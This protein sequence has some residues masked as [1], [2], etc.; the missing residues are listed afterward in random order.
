MLLAGS[1]RKADQRVSVAT[2]DEH[3]E[4]LN[5]LREFYSNHSF[6]F[7][8]FVFRADSFY[9]LREN[10]RIIAGLSAIPTEYVIHNVPG[11]GG[12]IMMKIL[13][14]APFFRRLFNPGLFRFV[15]L[16][17]IFYLPGREDA[18]TP[19]F[20]SVCAAKGI[21]TALDVGRSGIAAI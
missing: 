14:F 12:W 11:A 5:R 8:Q 7:E 9:V 18:L 4:I 3:G 6:Y 20:E 17:Y 15:S 16:G 21:N 2:P 1:V 10:G 19:L 13:P